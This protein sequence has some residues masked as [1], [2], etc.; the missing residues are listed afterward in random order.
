MFTDFHLAASKA[1]VATSVG[2]ATLA[3]LGHLGSDDANSLHTSL[4]RH[5]ASQGYAAGHISLLEYVPHARRAAVEAETSQL[6]NRTIDIQQ[7]VDNANISRGFVTR[8]NL[9]E[10]AVYTN[11]F[12][13]DDP[14][15]QDFAGFDFLRCVILAGQALCRAEVR[16]RSALAFHPPGRW[17]PAHTHSL[18][19]AACPCV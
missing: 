9:T 6:W 16:L 3:G 10:Y 17:H 12:D 15:L 8:P 19:A 4:A 13:L 7:Y 18:L 2:A 14:S 1:F 5:L 11:V